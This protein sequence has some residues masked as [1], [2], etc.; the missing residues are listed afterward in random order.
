MIDT[1]LDTTIAAFSGQVVVLDTQGPLLYI[2]T[3]AE[4]GR[5]FLMLLD[6][7][8]HDRHDSAVSKEQYVQQT[9]ELGV[10]VNRARVVVVRREMASIS[11]LSEVRME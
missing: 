6:A 8:V 5:D 11:L 1:T 7:D 2:G 10:R 4:V 3:L 9:A